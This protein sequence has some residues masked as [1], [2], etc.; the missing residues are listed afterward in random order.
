MKPAQTPTVAGEASLRIASSWS[1]ENTY[2]VL[3]L[4]CGVTGH[5]SPQTGL[6][7]SRPCSHAV[8]LTYRIGV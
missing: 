6:E 4:H 5:I 3:L 2:T 8:G 1:N 7:I